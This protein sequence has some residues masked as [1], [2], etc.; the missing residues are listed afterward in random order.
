MGGLHQFPGPLWPVLPV[1][2]IITV[3]EKFLAEY[4]RGEEP[5]DSNGDIR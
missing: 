3:L 1:I 4:G 5:L 2:A